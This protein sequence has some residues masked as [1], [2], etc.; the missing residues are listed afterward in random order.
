VYAPDVF[1]WSNNGL[2]VWAQVGSGECY[3][4][5][6]QGNRVYYLNETGQPNAG[7]NAGNC[8]EIIGWDDNV[9]TDTSLT[10]AI[11]DTVIPECE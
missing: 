1:S 8:G 11:W 7:W 10:A 4:H 3:G 5:Q 9:F 2:F 6:V